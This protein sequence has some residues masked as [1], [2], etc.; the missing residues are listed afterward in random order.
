[1]SIGSSILAHYLI[2][3]R[4]E[5]GFAALAVQSESDP[6]SMESIRQSVHDQVLNL[7]TEIS[8]HIQAISDNHTSLQTERS[9]RL[10]KQIEELQA[11]VEKEQDLRRESELKV[12]Q[13]QDQLSKTESEPSLTEG[14]AQQKNR[15]LLDHE[16]DFCRYRAD[17]VAELNRLNKSVQQTIAETKTKD[18]KCEALRQTSV[19]LTTKLESTRKERSKLFDDN[20]QF[21][22]S[23]ESLREVIKDKTK[24]SDRRQ[25]ELRLANQSKMQLETEKERLSATMVKLR[26]EI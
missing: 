20:F 4:T 11:S 10:T 21:K 26:E 14:T 22:L 6:S 18:R 1:M 15:R 16:R 24:E 17:A 19:D 12:V 2:I 25:E 13:L 5:S 7:R 3:D 23:N 9:T 8:Q